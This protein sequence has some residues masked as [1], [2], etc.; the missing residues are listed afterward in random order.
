MP[1]AVVIHLDPWPRALRLQPVFPIST[2]FILLLQWPKRGPHWPTFMTSIEL[3]IIIIILSHGRCSNL[4]ESRVIIKAMTSK[5][6]SS[7]LSVWN[8]WNIDRKLRNSKGIITDDN[9]DN[10]VSLYFQYLQIWENIYA[11]RCFFFTVVY[12]FVLTKLSSDCFKFSL[13]TSWSVYITTKLER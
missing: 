8:N 1:N 7:K 9:N 10:S 13:F 11:L 3:L 12:I 6:K 5:I 2:A 4:T